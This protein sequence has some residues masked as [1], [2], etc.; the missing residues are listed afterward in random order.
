LI[1][2]G[3]RLSLAM[4]ERGPLCVGIDPHPS[5]LG[6]WGL[7]DDP[8]GLE[9]FSLSAAEALA[10]VAAAVKPQSAFFER[11]GSKGIAVLER[12][13]EICREA[14]T[15]VI[16]DVKRGDI[17]STT[18]A[19]AEAYLHPR[20]SLCADAITASPYLGFGSLQ[21]MIDLAREHG[22]GVFVLALTSNPE[23]APV[24]RA[25]AASGT[26]AG[27]VLSQLKALNQ[28]ARPQWDL[29]GPWLG[30]RSA[31]PMKTW[32]SVGHYSSPGWG[33]RVALRQ[34]Y[35]GSSPE[36]LIWCC[37][38]AL[39]RSLGKGQIQPPSPRLL[40]VRLRTL[41]PWQLVTRLIS[42][43]HPGS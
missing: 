23:A 41:R 21:P 32:P 2:F 38:P 5:L 25:K 31:R 37:P 15:Q 13:I 11:H 35:A 17:G 19:Y 28:A 33:L 3:E 30:P 8:S 26:V 43:P 27:E 24:Q 40:V 16:L 4:Q 12:V 18:Q 1:P 9:R 6:Q 34:T 7:R 22:N 20:S 14:G 36:H 39:A 29:S 10:P 42:P